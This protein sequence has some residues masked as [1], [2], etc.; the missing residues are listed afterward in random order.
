M[1]AT[2]DQFSKGVIAFM[3]R[4]ALLEEGASRLRNANE[5]LNKRRRARYPHSLF[6][7]TALWT[8]ANPT[9]L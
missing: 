9:I 3:H 2:M 8:L 1:I 4:I 7:Y 6:D 5:A